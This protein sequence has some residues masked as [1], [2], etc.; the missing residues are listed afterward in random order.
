MP[1]LLA[2]GNLEEISSNL[3]NAFEAIVPTCREAKD[4]LVSNGALGA[5]MSGSGSAIYG[6]FPPDADCTAAC[7]ALARRGY[8]AFVC[9]PL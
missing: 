9:H 4:L 6:I 5:L 3:Y 7:R 2:G 8:T 1:A